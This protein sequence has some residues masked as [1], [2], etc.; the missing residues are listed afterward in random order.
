MA[1]V[2]RTEDGAIDVVDL[3]TGAATIT[4]FDKN[5]I[6]QYVAEVDMSGIPPEEVEYRMANP[7]RS[8]DIR[9]IFDGK[10]VLESN[11]DWQGDTPRIVAYAISLSTGEVQR[12]TLCSSG[13]VR[14]AR[15]IIIKGETGGDFFVHR[16]YIYASFVDVSPDGAPRKEAYIT[17]QYALISKADFYASNPNYRDFTLS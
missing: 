9:G 8:Y 10:L 13:E 5:S 12:I 17:H 6:K 2:L 7:P 1:Y 16:D 3:I 4:S 11:E 14:D 15:P